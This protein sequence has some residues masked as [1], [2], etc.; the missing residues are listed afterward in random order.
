MKFTINTLVL[1]SFGVFARAAPENHLRRNL[2][3]NDSN[4]NHNPDQPP[5]FM[6]EPLNDGRNLREMCLCAPMLDSAQILQFKY[7]GRQENA[8]CKSWKEKAMLH[9]FALILIPIYSFI[10][11]LISIFLISLTHIN[12]LCTL[13]PKSNKNRP[14]VK[15][16]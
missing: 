5:P 14:N 1:L 6:A 15:L 3:G 9:T 13:S 7:R 4:N 8:E 11:L 16:E 10:H 2:H 12:P